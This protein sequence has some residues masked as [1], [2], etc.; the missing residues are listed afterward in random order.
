M[1]LTVLFGAK[2]LQVLVFLGRTSLLGKDPVGALV[3]P[4]HVRPCGL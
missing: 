4:E 1:G 2:S 3:L